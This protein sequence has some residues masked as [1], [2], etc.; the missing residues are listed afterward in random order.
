MNIFGISVLYHDS[1]AAV[2]TD[3]VIVAAMQEE[4]LTRK[5]HDRRFPI[6]A[7][8]Y[9]L[10]LVDCIVYYDNPLITLD[11]Y[12]DNLFLR[13]ILLTICFRRGLMKCFPAN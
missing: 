12:L 5:K 4:R 7:V 9:C 11:R 3:G 10:S 8:N 1:A 6:N 2:I 13:R